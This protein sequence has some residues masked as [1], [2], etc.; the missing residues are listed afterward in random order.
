[1]AVPPTAP[2]YP[3]AMPPSYEETTGPGYPPYPYPAP[4]PGAGPAVKGGYGT[5]QP[6]PGQPATTVVPTPGMA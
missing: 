5:A 4:G 1:M 2:G 3:A 6:Y